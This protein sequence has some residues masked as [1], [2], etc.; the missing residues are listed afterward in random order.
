M[1]KIVVEKWDIYGAFKIIEE[2][3]PL[4][5]WKENKRQCRVMCLDCL[6]DNYL[7]LLQHLRQ[8]NIPSCDM[9]NNIRAVRTKEQLSK[10]N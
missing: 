2:V 7:I 4:D 5:T 3:E 1:R 6:N 10:D 8:R 9:C